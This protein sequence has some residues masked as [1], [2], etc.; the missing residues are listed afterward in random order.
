AHMNSKGTE[1]MSIVALVTGGSR[2]NEIGFKI[3]KF[4]KVKYPWS[5]EIANFPK[6]LKAPYPWD[7]VVMATKNKK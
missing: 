4:D 7:W 1:E 2:L 6:S 5:T 3:V